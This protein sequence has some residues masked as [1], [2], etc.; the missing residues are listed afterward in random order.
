M[1]EILIVTYDVDEEKNEKGIC[2]SRV[3]KEKSSFNVIKMALDE[4]AETLYKLITD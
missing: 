3:E 2:I 4:E 1:T